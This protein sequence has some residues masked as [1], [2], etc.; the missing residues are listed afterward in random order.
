MVGR[1][2]VPSF[3]RRASAFKLP[4]IARRP[5]AVVANPELEPEAQEPNCTYASKASA[6]PVCRLRLSLALAVVRGTAS[7]NETASD[8][9]PSGS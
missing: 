4:T 6:G 3:A 1:H 8:S 7:G 2:L 9:D 5:S